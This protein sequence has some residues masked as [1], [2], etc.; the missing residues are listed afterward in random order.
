[1]KQ[2][3][4]VWETLSRSIRPGCINGDGFDAYA[5]ALLIGD[6]IYALDAKDK[7]IPYADNSYSPFDNHGKLSRIIAEELYRGIAQF[8]HQGKWGFMD[9][10]TGKI[11]VP[12][13]FDYVSSLG[14]K[15]YDWRNPEAYAFARKNGLAGII[16]QDGKPIIPL[17][18]DD[19]LWND[20]YYAAPEAP[21]FVRRKKL[22]GAVDMAGNILAPVKWRSI[23]DV[24]DYLDGRKPCSW[25]KLRQERRQHKESIKRLIESMFS[26]F[27]AIENSK[28]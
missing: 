25:K 21:I 3:C 26:K 27:A 17:I 20:C 9:V 16:N 12:A 23:R 8:S 5:D 19:L 22:W 1:M 6:T 13:E 4:T 14:P 24:R 28:K 2:T 18:W 7:I 11:R 15:Y 10:Y